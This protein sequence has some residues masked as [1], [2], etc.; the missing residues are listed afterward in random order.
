MRVP[1][2]TS[3][4]DCFHNMWEV[5]K[6]IAR[7]SGGWGSCVKGVLMQEKTVV[8]SSVKHDRRPRSANY[9]FCSF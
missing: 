8:L 6:A 5:N 2:R 1:C 7:G 9:I 3:S 4:P